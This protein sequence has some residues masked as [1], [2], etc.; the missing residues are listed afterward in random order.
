M[1]PLLE[2]ATKLKSERNVACGNVYWRIMDTENDCSRSPRSWRMILLAYRS[3][4]S[5]CHQDEESKYKN[6]HGPIEVYFFWR[7]IYLSLSVGTYTCVHAEGKNRVV[8]LELELQVFVGHGSWD[9]N[10]GPLVSK[11][12]TPEPTPPYPTLELI[13]KQ[14]VQMCTVSFL[15]GQTWYSTLTAHQHC[16]QSS[17]CFYSLFS[18]L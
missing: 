13:Q 8:S 1:T 11:H 17:V 3:E 10:S 5:D 6:F 15:T 9:P 14:L 16:W 7:L 2:T 4:I 18:L 12:S